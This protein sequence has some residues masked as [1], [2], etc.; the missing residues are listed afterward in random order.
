MNLGSSGRA[1]LLGEMTSILN[2]SPS[3][4][5]APGV[6][7]AAGFWSDRNHNKQ[8]IYNSGDGER[9]GSKCIRQGWGTTG[10]LWPRD[11]KNVL[12]RRCVI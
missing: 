5:S 3:N 12:R 9:S 11:Q 2:Y 1:E 8:V 6:G 4:Y 10:A 7:D